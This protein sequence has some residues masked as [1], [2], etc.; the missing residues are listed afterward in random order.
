MK[1]VIFVIGLLV[2]FSAS[3]KQCDESVLNAVEWRECVATENTKPVEKAYQDLLKA[4][5]DSESITQNAREAQ[6]TWE[7]FRNATCVY[8]GETTTRE[9]QA[10][11]FDEFNKARVKMLNQ[12]AKQASKK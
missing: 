6:S 5:K 11:C 4:H 10:V 12:Y 9:D 7:A 2:T 8:V 3:A 1:K